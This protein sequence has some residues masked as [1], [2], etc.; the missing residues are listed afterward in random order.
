MVS[1]TDL[2]KICDEVWNTL[3]IEETYDQL[4]EKFVK[5]GDEGYLMQMLG[6]VTLDE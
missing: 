3:W 5:T 4:R 6:K 2:D 1:A